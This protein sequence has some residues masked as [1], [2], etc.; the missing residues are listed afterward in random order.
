MHCGSE[1]VHT[2]PNLL[3]VLREGRVPPAAGGSYENQGSDRVSRGSVVLPS[4]TCWFA[5]LEVPMNGDGSA[6][7]TLGRQ[8][9]GPS[10]APGEASLVVP[11]GE[12]RALLALLQGLFAQARQDG[13]IPGQDG[14]IPGPERA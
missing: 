2:S 11:P 3:W 8:A 13:V 7:L 10:I 5:K 12:A 4:G 14:V 1:T 6:L 9:A